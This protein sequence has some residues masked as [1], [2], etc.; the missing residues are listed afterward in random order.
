MTPELKD[1]IVHKIS[2][3]HIEIPQFNDNNIDLTPKTI[4]YLS[5]KKT[6]DR[7]QGDK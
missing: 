7:E 5:T 3:M 1:S 2:K 6:K 4:Y